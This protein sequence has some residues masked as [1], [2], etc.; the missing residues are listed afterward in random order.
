MVPPDTEH[1]RF[2]VGFGSTDAALDGLRPLLALAAQPERFVI[3][4]EAAYLYCP[5]GLL[6]SKVSE[7]MLGRFGKTVTARNWATTLKIAAL[8]A[9]D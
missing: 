9:Q 4:P 3:R 6:Q 1:S 5:S 7:A 8:L 2:L